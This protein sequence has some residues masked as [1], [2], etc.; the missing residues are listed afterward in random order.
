MQSP[1]RSEGKL[2]LVEELRSCAGIKSMMQLNRRASPSP[3]PPRALAALKAWRLGSLFPSL[4]LTAPQCNPAP[5]KPIHLFLISS[6]FAR[7]I[8]LY[9][10]A[11]GPISFVVYGTIHQLFAMADKPFHVIVVG[12]GKQ[13]TAW[14][15]VIIVLL[16]FEKQVSLA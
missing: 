15:T 3:A 8:L 4:L 16:T 14:K 2:D 7:H 11:K 9:A 13:L 1:D 12:A 10:E 5:L 6:T